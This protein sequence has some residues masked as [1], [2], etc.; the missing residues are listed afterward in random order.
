MVIMYNSSDPNKHNTD[1][2][3]W[4]SIENIVLSNKGERAPPRYSYEHVVHGGATH[5][6]SRRQNGR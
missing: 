1:Y 4:I 2:I 6:A 5:D 3:I